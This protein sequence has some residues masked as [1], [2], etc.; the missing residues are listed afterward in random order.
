MAKDFVDRFIEMAKLRSESRYNPMLTK[1]EN[2]ARMAAAARELA[3]LEKEQT[4][5]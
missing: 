1:E 4:H 2:D 3:R 5:G